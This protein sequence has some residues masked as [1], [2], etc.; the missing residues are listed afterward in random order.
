MKTSKKSLVLF[1]AFFIS[2]LFVCNAHAQSGEILDNQGVVELVK[3]GLPGSIIIKKIQSSPNKFDLSTEALV[4]L[5]NDGVPEDII[6]VMMES[7]GN[8]ISEHHDLLVKLGEPGIYH[9]IQEEPNLEFAFLDPSVID[10]V[11]EGNFGSHMA[12]ALTAAAKKKVRAIVANGQANLKTSTKP[13]FL[14]YFGDPNSK[15]AAPESPKADPNDP[16]AMIRAL[17]GMNTAQK[18]KFSGISSPNELR[19]VKTDADK[20]ERAFIAS[21]A[22]GMVRESGID[23]DYV[24][25]FKF[26]RIAPGLFRVYMDRPLEPGEYLFIYAGIA[27]Y[28]GQYVY[29]FSAK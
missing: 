29:D 11:K 1:V 28:Q 23:S 3:S 17:Q 20:K 13:V 26:D 5:T 21:S 9:V 4:K 16:M 12:G 18:I 10:K 6:A 27:L 19:L 14:F 22:S 25:Q 15:D 24:R 2:V 7:K 8:T